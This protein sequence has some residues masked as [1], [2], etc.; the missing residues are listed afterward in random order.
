MVS[1]GTFIS[2]ILLLV[3]FGG[4]AQAS[5]ITQTQLGLDQRIQEMN[6]KS[7]RLLAKRRQQTD[8]LK[9]R[10]HRVQNFLIRRDPTGSGLKEEEAPVYKQALEKKTM[11]PRLPAPETA[12]PGPESHSR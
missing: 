7:A 10:E 11:L 2:F 4:F 1:H 8:E 12:L 3:L 6:A 9:S 5:W